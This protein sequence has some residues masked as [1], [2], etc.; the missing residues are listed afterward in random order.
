M[1]G[2]V[3]SLL[4]ATWLLLFFS[5]VLGSL[6]VEDELHEGEASILDSVF[7]LSVHDRSLVAEDVS[8][9]SILSQHKHHGPE[10]HFKKF[11]EMTLA[12][13][14]PWN[15]HG[16]D[17][18]KIFRG[19]FTHVSP[20]WYYLKPRPNHQYVLEGGH[21]YDK[22]WIDEVRFFDPIE[23]AGSA[24]KIVPRVQFSEW[25]RDEFIHIL[26]DAD[27]AQ[28]VVNL[29]VEEAL[30]K[31]YDGLVLEMGGV[32]RYFKGIIR[33]LA[34]RLH[35]SS[36]S[37]ILV[38]PPYFP[39]DAHVGFS[40]DDYSDL[41]DAVDGFSLMTYDYGNRMGPGPNSPI[42]WVQANIRYLC[43]DGDDRHKL[44]VGL[45]M[46]GSDYTSSE[47]EAVIASQ[48]LEL[49]EKHNPSI[50]WSEDDAEHY[51]NY[52]DQKGTHMVWYPTLKSI[53][54]RIALAEEYGT[55]LSFWEVGQ[56]LDYFYD[57]L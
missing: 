37:L 56:G 47:G 18:V 26:N 3:R 9:N 39:D 21:D 8:A 15:N 42:E 13:V 23:N 52:H 14:T 50:V 48:Y 38:I 57:L 49:L 7:S 51:F 43:P 33:H 53:H 40:N 34:D 54:D 29:M 44:L 36:K 31:D 4:R 17:V 27:A 35:E 32:A 16:Y 10:S 46:Y 22:G 45:N 30:D 41:V 19:K 25:T 55:G 5:C 11:S 1:P 28:R 24:A 20:V 2:R 6:V 12:Y